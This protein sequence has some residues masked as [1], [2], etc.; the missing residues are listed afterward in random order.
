MECLSFLSSMQTYGLHR[1][2]N[3]VDP[4]PLPLP[5]PLILLTFY[6]L[7]TIAGYQ[8]PLPNLRQPQLIRYIIIVLFRRTCANAEPPHI[9]YDFRDFANLLTSNFA[10]KLPKWPAVRLCNLPI[11]TVSPYGLVIPRYQTHSPVRLARL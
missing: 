10:A 9:P 4:L 8:V 7:T 2:R 11:A 1:I 3:V 6:L 5:S